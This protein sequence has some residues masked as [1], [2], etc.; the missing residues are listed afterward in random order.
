MGM[1]ISIQA[2]INASLARLLKGSWLIS[3]QCGSILAAFISFGVGTLCLGIIAYVSGAFHID[4]AKSLL[5]LH[6]W[7]QSWWKFLGGAL[8][9]FFVFGTILLAPKIGLVNMFLLALVGQLITSAVLDCVGAFGL[10]IKPISL[11][12][13]LGLGIILVGLLVFFSK[14]LQKTRFM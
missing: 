1:A 9:A 6:F 12:K 4:I 13:I 14:E 11:Q 8:G 5:Q 7:Q 3:L 10:S 2:P